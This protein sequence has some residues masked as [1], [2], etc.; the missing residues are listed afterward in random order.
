MPDDLKAYVTTVGTSPEAVFNPLWY[1]VEAY[2]WIPD[3]VYLLWND[4]VREQLERVKEL[5]RRLSEA[6]GVEIKIKAGDGQRFREENPIEFRE[7]AGSLIGSLVSEGHEVVVDITPGRKFMSALLLGAAMAK[8]ADEITYLHLDDW[9]NYIGKLLFEVPMSKQRLFRKGELTGKSGTAK[10]GKRRRESPSEAIPVEREK[11]MAVLD[12][13]YLDGV[14]R[15][16]LKVRSRVIGDVTLGESAKLRVSNNIELDEDLHGGHTMVKEALIAGGMAKFRNWEELVSV[17]NRLKGDGRPL[18]IG[19]DTNALYFRV[20]SKILAEGRFYSGGN[21]IF[22]FV[23]SDEVAVEVGRH[24]NKKLPYDRALGMYSNQPTP[25]ARLG[26]LGR[27]ELEKIKERG[28]E[29]TSSRESFHGDT[30]IA[31]DYKVF[32]EEKDANVLVITLDDRAYSEMKTLRGSGL[33]P[34]KLEWDF[35]FGDTLEGTWEELRDTLYTLAVTLG[36]LN[37]A[38]Y[39]LYGIWHGKSSKDWENERVKLTGFEYGRILRVLS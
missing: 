39:K 27:V 5:I 25:R 20:P 16:P 7:K 26:S 36:E 38:G 14:T 3:R 24:L 28:A 29:R 22:D 9:R 4:D 34:L 31:L 32:A 33:I 18:Y 17:I 11:L 37:F 10:L 35:S 23:Y 2:N 1:L 21:L 12:S 19:F 13:L 15:F 6:Y 8:G 30:K